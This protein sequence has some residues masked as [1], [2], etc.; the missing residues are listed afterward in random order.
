MKLP[1]TAADVTFECGDDWGLGFKCGVVTGL[2]FRVR[3][4]YADYVEP[5]HN[6]D[7]TKHLGNK[8]NRL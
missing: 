4:A 8:A 2:G 5:A 3:L 1:L 7:S 6:H